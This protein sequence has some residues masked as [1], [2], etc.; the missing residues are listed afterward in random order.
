MGCFVVTTG[1]HRFKYKLI[2]NTDLPENPKTKS[3]SFPIEKNWLL[4][5][6]LILNYPNSLE[7]RLRSVSSRNI[8]RILK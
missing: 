4:K 8:L 1:S 6:N 7:R 3:Q 2:S 5:F